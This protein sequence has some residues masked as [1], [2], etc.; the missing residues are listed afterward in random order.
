MKPN[1]LHPKSPL[2]RCSQPCGF[3][4]IVTLSLMILLT[5]IAVGLLS[6]SSISLRSSSQGDAMQSARANARIA[7]MLAIG[8]LQKQLGPDTRISATADQIPAAGSN[9][10]ESATPRTQRQW[11]GA[12]KSWPTAAP[13]ATRPAPE[14]LQW[15]ISGDP[16][17]I[18][19]KAYAG[20]AISVD[21]KDSV[22]IVTTN[23][24]GAADTVRVPLVTQPNSNGTKNSCAWWVSDLG[25]KALVVPAKDIPT[26]LAEVRV[27]QQTAPA[28]NLKSAL[29][30]IE[31]PFQS[32]SLT[33]PR[34]AN[35]ATWHSSGL[36]ADNPQ[37]IKALFHDFTAQSRGLITNVRK[38]GFRKDLSME[39]ERTSPPTS[40]GANALYT[41]GGETGI[42]L[43]ELWTYYN[44]YSPTNYKK[45]I[46][47]SGAANFTTGGSMP[48]GTPYLQLEGTPALSQQDDG[49]FFKQP[50]IISYQV[51]LS[52]QARPF[53]GTG[54][55]SLHLVA[56][57]IITFWNPLDVPV[58]VSAGSFFTV[59]YWPVPYTLSI[60]K[61]GVAPQLFPMAAALSG[62]SS[63]SNGDFNFMSLEV[64]QLQQ[65]VFKP[66]EVIK[67][68][69]VGNTLARSGIPDMHKV[70]GNKGFNFGG[71][72]A[73][74]IRD[75]GGNPISLQPTDTISF[76]AT[77]NNIT[78]GA[79]DSSGRS[80][81]GGSAHSRH[82]SLTHHEYYIGADR[83]D[84]NASLGIGGVF[85]DWDFG[86]RRLRLGED[87]GASAPGIAGTKSSS[88]RYYASDTDLKDVFKPIGGRPMPASILSVKQPFMLQSFSVKTG[89]IEK[90]VGN[91]S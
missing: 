52:L 18:N 73:L 59:K 14:F 77:P 3:A 40:N 28:A 31:K 46:K 23:S 19:A 20:T 11:A 57:P 15:F 17:R 89:T 1:H 7:L 4:L 61:N 76:T 21:P 78:A 56:D 63:N 6:L 47:R 81:T 53:E 86:N 67:M 27:D 69:Q 44:L 54:V 79:T 13:N 8:D 90:R 48:S 72:V 84:G 49:F 66:G 58:V 71:G 82:F 33:D 38:G 62:A 42:N 87:R 43:Q 5:V 30:G 83:G 9:P 91:G 80:V 65:I 50:V 45:G 51:A 26:A 75:A 22:Q 32:V 34:L 35:I 10:T 60:S 12:Y 70:G 37:N 64:G 39:L 74:G 41:V 36:L 68:S 88:D 29:S 24:V 16:T 25:T 55:N 85:L 2:F